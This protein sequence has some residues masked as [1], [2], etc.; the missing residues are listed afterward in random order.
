MQNK[1][2]EVTKTHYTLENRDVFEHT[3]DIDENINVGEFQKMLDNAKSVVLETINKI[4]NGE[5]D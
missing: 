1:V 2:V 4:E 3:F 5:L